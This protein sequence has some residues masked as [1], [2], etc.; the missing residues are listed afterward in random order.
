VHGVALS[1]HEG[2]APLVVPAHRKGG[3]DTPSAHLATSA[4]ETG[5]AAFDVKLA[6]LDDFAF[7][8]VDFVKIDV[9]GFEE[10]VLDGGWRTITACR[11]LMLIEL[12]DRL[13]PGCLARVAERLRTIAYDVRFLDGGAWL[14]LTRLGPGDTGP[15]GRFIPNFLFFPAEKP[16]IAAAADGA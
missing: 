7:A 15:S 13:R 14:P 3:L 5:A 1:D 12:V 9:E 8:D 6:R 11:P 16:E 10:S 2:T 4:G